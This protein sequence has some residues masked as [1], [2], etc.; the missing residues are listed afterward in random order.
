MLYI[1]DAQLRAEQAAAAL[2]KDGAEERLV[3]ALR[4]TAEVLGAEHSRLLRRSHF[5][6]TDEDWEEVRARKRAAAG[7]QSELEG[8]TRR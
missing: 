1:A 5:Y 3:V 4:E 6:V 7:D 2:E 8:S